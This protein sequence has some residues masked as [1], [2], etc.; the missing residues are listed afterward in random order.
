MYIAQAVSPAFSAR[1]VWTA[2]VGQ[3]AYV[4]VALGL[5]QSCIRPHMRVSRSSIFDTAGPIDVQGGALVTAGHFPANLTSGGMMSPPRSRIRDG[6]APGGRHHSVRRRPATTPNNGD[7]PL[8]QSGRATSAVELDL[9]RR[10]GCRFHGRAVWHHALGDEPPQR[11][12]QLPRQRHHHHLSHAG[13]RRAG[14]L[15]KPADVS[16]AGLIALPRPK[17]TRSSRS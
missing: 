14:A 6:R 2:P 5:E 16:G 4:V 9:R 12:Q 3:G 13:A 17:P 10:S 1:H 7:A 11:D 15:T 8:D